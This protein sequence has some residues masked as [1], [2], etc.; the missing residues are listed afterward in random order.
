MTVPVSSVGADAEQPFTKN[1]IKS[2][3]DLSDKGNLQATNNRI[4]S[5]DSNDSQTV[6]T[7]ELYDTAYPPKLPIVEGL[8][9]KRIT[10]IAACIKEMTR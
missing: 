6:S 8:L 10:A 4:K 3:A 9:Y 5:N 1:T 2:I 7:T